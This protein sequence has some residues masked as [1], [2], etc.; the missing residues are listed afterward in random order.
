MRFVSVIVLL[1]SFRTPKKSHTSFKYLISKHM[2][3]VLHTKGL[4]LSSSCADLRTLS[5]RP[6][7]LPKKSHTSF[8]YRLPKNIGEVLHTKELHFSSSCA[9]LRTLSSR[10][11]VLSKTSHNSSKYRLSKNVGAVLRRG[12]IF[13]LLV[14]I[15]EPSLAVLPSSLL[16]PNQCVSSVFHDE[17]RVEV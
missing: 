3:A 8:K 7:V 9:D 2:G 5:R 4:H 12:Y 17:T 15:F 1:S 16:P 10:P 14:Q 13:L 6:S 11:S